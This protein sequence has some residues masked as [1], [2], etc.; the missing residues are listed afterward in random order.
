[1]KEKGKSQEMKYNFVAVR[2]TETKP[3]PGPLVLKLGANQTT[4]YFKPF[5]RNKRKLWENIE[6][7]LMCLI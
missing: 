4:L 1:M 6:H 7:D 3:C 5:H 2:G